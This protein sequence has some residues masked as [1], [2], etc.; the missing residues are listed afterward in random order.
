MASSYSR[1][2]LFLRRCS[3]PRQGKGDA[4]IA[5]YHQALSLKPDDVFAGEMLKKALEVRLG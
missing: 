4:A 5:G 1:C 3:I 2:R